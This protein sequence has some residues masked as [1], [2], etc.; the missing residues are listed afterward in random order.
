MAIKNHILSILILSLSSMT[1][2]MAQDQF[3]STH[4]GLKY[5]YFVDKS[6]P[7]AKTGDLVSLHM[8]MENEKGEVL[9]STYKEGRPLLFPVKISAFEG[10]LYEGVGMLSAGDS[11]AFSIPADSMYIKV[12]KKP[13][14]ENVESGTDLLFTIKVLNVQSQRDRLSELQKSDSLKQAELKQEIED[15]K[16]A[17][18]KA[19]TSYL[20]DQ[21][22]LDKAQ[23]TPGGAYVI[24]DKRGKGKEISEGDSPSFHYIGKVF[25][26]EEFESSYDHKPV[27][28]TVGESNVIP[29][30]NE[31]FKFLHG[32]DMA[33][34]I[35]PS[36]LAYS[37]RKKGEKIPS[38]SVLHF[39]IEVLNVK[40]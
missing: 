6:T 3:K 5:R 30:W 24:I 31:G 15:K 36:H 32:G 20:S 40:R 37:F 35:I 18:E 13:L 27:S 8:V 38:F 34:M 21:G 14:P 25:K 28:F 26:G 12:F 17:Q 33:T 4:T 2:L 10:D 29:G 9:R 16:A 7:Q 11:A 23:R 1:A 39:E 19:I 22:L